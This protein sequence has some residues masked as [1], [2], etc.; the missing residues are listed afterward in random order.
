VIGRV[1][2]L[3]RWEDVLLAAVALVGLPLLELVRGAGA[4]TDPGT[5]EPTALT[6][7]FGLVAVLGVL[8]CLCT[9]G[10]GEPPPLADG[11]LTLQGWARFPLAAGVGIVALET[12]PGIGLDGEPFTGLTFLVVVV[13]AV[14]GGFLP[15][16]PVALRRALVTPM[17]VLAAGAFDEVMGEGLGGLL[18]DAARGEVPPEVAAFLPLIV[19]AAATLYV[20]LV[21][22]PRAIADPGASGGAWA[23]RFLLLLAAAVSGN[24][25]LGLL[26]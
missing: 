23:V 5:G 3:L 17:A 24:A 10:P 16:V 11:Q 14:A 21:V 7:A 6:G 9:R 26:G 20:M 12:L 25:L 15:V 22:A 4:A 8:A 2:G 19:A 18:G 1:T 13:T